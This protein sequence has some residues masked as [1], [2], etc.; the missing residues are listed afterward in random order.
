MLLQTTES[1]HLVNCADML[2]I[3]LSYAGF[4]RQRQASVN[5]DSNIERFKDHY[6]LPPKTVS[7]VYN[8]LG[9]EFDDIIVKDFTMTLKWFKGYDVKHVLDGRW[10]YCE[11]YNPR[12]SERIFQA[13]AIFQAEEN[14]YFEVLVRRRSTAILLMVSILKL[15]NLQRNLVQNGIPSKTIVVV[16]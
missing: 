9:N 8:D 16:L 1:P 7:S 4:D 14:L 15:M 11:K 10:Q 6:G 5:L 3:G 2:S 12:K 13:A